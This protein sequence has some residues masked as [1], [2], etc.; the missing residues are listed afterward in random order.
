MKNKAPKIDSK[1][2][3]IIVQ[4]PIVGKTSDRLSKQ[5]T[6]KCLQ[7]IRKIFTQSEIILST[8]ENSSTENLEYDILLENKDP[9]QIPFGNP[10]VNRQIL[11]VKEGLKKATRKYVIK[12]RTDIEFKHSDFLN[13]FDKFS[14]HCED[15]NIL[16]KRV[17]IT[18]YFARD[19]KKKIKLYFH[20]SDMFMFGLKGDIENIW[21]IPLVSAAELCEFTKE[22]TNTDLRRFKYGIYKYVPEQYIWISFLKKHSEI[23]FENY[24][25]IKSSTLE[26]SEKSIVNNLIIVDWKK[27]G[28]KIHKFYFDNKLSTYSHL[29]WLELYQK[30]CDQDFKFKNVSI[31]YE[32]KHNINKTLKEVSKILPYF[33][34]KKFVKG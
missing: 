13:Y 33:M 14:H 26:E 6:R 27:A 23:K 25:D 15:F 12:T 1:D 5:Y 22:I 21:N 31:P 18:N 30:Y 28:L 11:G 2:I 10:N 7:S 19:P 4:G 20:P 24:L 9:G 3:S 8:W 32:V 17:I 29:A 34:V 16:E